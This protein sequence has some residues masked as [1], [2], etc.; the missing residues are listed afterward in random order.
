MEVT[1]KET[2][3]AFDADWCPKCA[4]TVSMERMHTGLPGICGKKC[5]ECGA[6]YQ[7]NF[8]ED[9]D[10]TLTVPDDFVMPNAELR[11]DAE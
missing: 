4:K 2:W 1:R 7:A 10:D 3:N 11:R 9:G 8:L 5:Q 6:N